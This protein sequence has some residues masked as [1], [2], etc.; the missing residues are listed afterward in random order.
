MPTE[1]TQPKGLTHEQFQY[2]LLSFESIDN[3]DKFVGKAFP[4][5]SYVEKF[6]MLGS[7]FNFAMV[8]GYIPDGQSEEDKAKD[9]YIFTLQHL[10][11]KVKVV[12]IKEV[13]KSLA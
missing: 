10:L 11:N 13:V 9:D 6:K 2:L 4:D 7:Y 12:G 5:F 8:S 1:L 3:A